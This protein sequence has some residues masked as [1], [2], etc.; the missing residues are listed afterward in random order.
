MRGMHAWHACVRAPG[1]RRGVCAARVTW[2]LRVTVTVG[3]RQS[4]GEGLV[5]VSRVTVTTVPVARP[6][7][8]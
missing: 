8:A 5:G 6:L 7:E 2:Q 3:V 4:R 1:R